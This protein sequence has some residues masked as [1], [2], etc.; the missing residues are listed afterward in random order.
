[1]K[2]KTSDKKTTPSA[3]DSNA[4]ATDDARNS[5][6]TRLDKLIHDQTHSEPPV[7]REQVLSALKNFVIELRTDPLSRTKEQ[8]AEFLA[9][10]LQNF[11]KKL[12]T[13]SDVDLIQQALLLDL[14]TPDAVVLTPPLCNTIVMLQDTIEEQQEK[15]RKLQEQMRELQQENACL[16]NQI[17]LLTEP[18]K[19]Q[20]NTRKSANSKQPKPELPNPEVTIKTPGETPDEQPAELPNPEVTIKTPGETPDEQ[21]AELTI[22]GAHNN[23]LSCTKAIVEIKQR[24]VK[25]R[26]SKCVERINDFATQENAILT[27]MQ[28]AT[29]DKKKPLAAKWLELVSQKESAEDELAEIMATVAVFAKFDEVCVQSLLTKFDKLIDTALSPATPP[30]ALTTASTATAAPTPALTTASTATAASTPALTTAST[31]TA[32]PTPALTKTTVLYAEVVQRRKK[33]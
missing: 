25:N 14:L 32:V 10:L 12:L 3:G 15:M 30:P 24:D 7:S 11:M 6:A 19:P 29:R 13:A 31:A 22:I 16:T 23:L 28:T 2:K 4:S 9:Q 26:H 17:S 1:M 18:P 21:P 27:E 33:K 20:K 8:I 5:V